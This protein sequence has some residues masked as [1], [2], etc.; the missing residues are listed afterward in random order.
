MR[1]T[2]IGTAL[3]VSMAALSL[4]AAAQFQDVLQRPSR[5]SPLAQRSLQNGLTVAGN[6]LVSV[7]QR[8]HI[9][10]S[11]DQ[12]RSW[13]QAAVPVSADLLAVHF[14]TPQHGWAVGHDGVVLHSADAGQTWTLQLDGVRTA[15][16]MR[17]HY[18]QFAPPEIAPQDLQGL[19]AD[20]DQWVLDGADKPFLDVWFE[21]ERSGFIVG[22]F[23]LIMRTDD[24]GQSWE[25]W[26]HR[27]DNPRGLHLYAIRPVAGAWM[28]VG[29][30][31]LV[32]RLDAAQRRFQQVPVPYG[33]TLFG[34]VG[35]G[36]TV[37]AFGLR[38]H[39][40][41]SADGGRTWRQVESNTGAN[42]NGGVLTPDGRVLLASQ[43]AM[44]LAS[45]DQGAHF[46][47]VALAQPMPAHA[48]AVLGDTLVVAGAR[49]LRAQP[50]K[51]AREG[52]RP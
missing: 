5:A 39:V 18:R 34:L 4:N 30:Q 28:A 15:Q 21:N 40:L 49:G 12:G 17:D 35:V 45:D 38:G 33:G 9:L 3:A 52:A 8:G 10:Y 26:Y 20:M 1:F 6:R 16:R 46:S 19:Q 37:I 36:P 31:G 43:G 22:A 51:I 25:P 14:P 41:R 44:L 11:D 50:W 27:T 29:E 23:N 7:G 48:V 24:G 2:R 47:P 42:L 13:H 32:L